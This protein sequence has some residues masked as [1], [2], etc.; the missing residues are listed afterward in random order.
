MPFEEKAE[1]ELLHCPSERYTGAENE[2]GTGR[3]PTSC[4][5]RFSCTKGRQ[6][7]QVQAVCSSIVARMPCGWSQE[8]P[9]AAP[10]LCYQVRSILNCKDKA[11][12]KGKLLVS[13]LVL[14]RQ[15]AFL[16]SPPNRIELEGS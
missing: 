9:A 6:L 11:P 12:K 15:R 1:Q 10:A 7:L 4:P 5:A 16:A 8:L 2:A 14:V 3:I 13:P